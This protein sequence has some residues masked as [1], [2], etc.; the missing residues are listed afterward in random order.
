MDDY[1]TEILNRKFKEVEEKIQKKVDKQEGGEKEFADAEKIKLRFDFD[2][3]R[4]KYSFLMREGIKVLEL[5]K[6][7][8]IL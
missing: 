7:G 4:E 2:K 1:L 5:V 6:R 8:E 3:D